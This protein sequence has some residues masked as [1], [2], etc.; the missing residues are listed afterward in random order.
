MAVPQ[1]TNPNDI[2]SVIAT[3]AGR[4]GNRPKGPPF[5]RARNAPPS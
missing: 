1:T 5:E 3:L 2:G 4:Q